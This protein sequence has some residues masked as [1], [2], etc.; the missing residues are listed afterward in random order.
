MS[1][2][3]PTAN[4]AYRME[5]HSPCAIWYLQHC[6]IAHARPFQHQSLPAD[7]TVL[8]WYLVAWPHSDGTFTVWTDCLR[9]RSSVGPETSR[10]LGQNL[11]RGPKTIQTASRRVHFSERFEPPWPQ[12]SPV[13]R[14]SGQNQILRRTG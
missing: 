8:N 1:L 13:Q 2:S 4:G 3:G 6:S 10:R 7:Q 14:N 9:H 5:N 11:R 12:Q